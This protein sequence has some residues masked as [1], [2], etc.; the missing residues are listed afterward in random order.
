MILRDWVS[1]NHILFAGPEGRTLVDTGY[2]GQVERTL[3]LLRQPANLGDERLDRVINTHCHSD[4]MGANARLKREYG[5]SISVPAGEGPLVERWDERG[6]WLSWTDQICERFTCDDLIE[7]GSPLSLGGAEWRA[8]EAPGHDMNAL[9]FHCPE[10]GLLISGDALWENGLGIVLTEDQSAGFRAARATLDNIA[11]L[12]VRA[13]IPGHGAPFR[14][15]SRALDRAYRRAD[16]FEADPL[17]AAG[18]YLKVM[19]MFALQEKGRMRLD[20]LPNLLDRVAF[21]REYNQRFFRLPP[22]TLADRMVSELERGL[23]ARREDGWL[24]PGAQGRSARG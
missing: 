24:L 2:G 5:C 15:V 20:D 19:L 18:H 21:Y 17:K 22:A 8:L 1:G 3:A 11:G 16:A 12:D 13:V 7:P 23:A 6:M 4:H 10:H 9:M 14:E